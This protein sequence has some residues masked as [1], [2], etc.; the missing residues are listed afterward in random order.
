MVFSAKTDVGRVRPHNEDCFGSYVSE[1]GS[2]LFLVVADGMG[3]QNAGE[4]ASKML[5]DCFMNKTSF[6]N[7]KNLTPEQLQD[8]LTDTIKEANLNI[9]KEAK[10]NSEQS[11][12]GTTAVACILQEDKLI[13]ANVGDS[14]AYVSSQSVLAKVTEDHSYVEDLVRKGAIS[15]EQARN[16]PDKNIITR[17]V[18]CMDDVE[19]DTFVK[20]FD[21][22]SVLLM[23][24]DGLS[25]MI[26]DDYMQRIIRRNKNMD[27]L[28]ERLIY[29]A[30]KNGGTDNITVIVARR[31]DEVI[32]G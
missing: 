7:K 28:A 17:A 26:E 22:N 4:V 32:H 19:V 29:V 1:D 20:D 6:L 5:V 24:S 2:V 25:N 11:G 12:M 16:H 9:L 23:C 31:S 8:F 15:Q 3:G 10:D 21:K 18:G 27:K 30:K 14:R 13:V